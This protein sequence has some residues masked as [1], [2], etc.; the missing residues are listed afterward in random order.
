ML[1]VS[2]PRP[3][4]PPVDPRPIY[5]ARLAERSATAARWARHDDVVVL[6]RVV[7][8]VVTGGLA[9][10]AWRTEAV[11]AMWLL[12]P[13]A[14]F[15]ALVV[16][17]DRVRR[18]L[19][20]A[21]R[22]AAFYE[23][24]LARLDDRWA[25]SGEDGL[26][27]LD[28]GHPYAVDLDLFGHGSL[29]QLLCTARTGL[30]EAT[31][32][33][34][35]LAPADP[36]PLR[37]RQAAVDELRPRLDLREEVALLGDDARSGADPAA[38]AAW[39]TRRDL[40]VSR[41]LRGLAAGFGLL[42]LAALGWWW[43]LGHG[44]A[45]LLVTATAAWLFSRTL[46]GR[47]SAVIAGAENLRRDLDVL[48]PL[49][50]RI[51]REPMDSPRLVSLQ[52]GLRREGRPPS[53]ALASLRRLVDLLAARGA[54]LFAP[55]AALLLFGTQL[56]LAIEAW[57]GR[58]GAELGDWLAA[59]GEVEAVLAL[60]GYAYEHPADPFPE[61]AA[62]S[63]CFEATVLAHP[64]LPNATRV[65][66]DIRLGAAE[67]V[68]LVSGSNMSGKSTL[69]RT[70]GVN[71]VLAGAGAPVRAERLRVSPLA[72]GAAIRMEDSLRDGVSHFYAEITR[73]QQILAL[74]DGPRPLLFLADE[75]LSGTNSRDRRIGTEAIV[76]RL[77]ERGAIGLATT[78]DLSLAELADALGPRVAN[79]HFADR[80]VDG[81]M[82]F[83]Y[84]LQPG[85]AL[86]SNAL[87]L[88][89]AIGLLE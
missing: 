72:L 46:H 74:A 3:G 32:A 31:L 59:V 28:R 30:G 84:R 29:F 51:E 18:W 89:R 23:R 70:V 71:A 36:D 33:D 52:A 24:G 43:P 64:L 26:R 76:R 82:V 42:N 78:H 80:L 58:Y 47:A 2:R 41:R 49:L 12:A 68:L 13:I 7:V 50:S 62:G 4:D 79:V 11:T 81:R 14:L 9:L 34:W 88:M 63:A 39:G 60:A 69:L 21:R 56:A 77:V 44:P 85:V 37:A 55:F 27:F 8:G 54:L 25:G 66:N 65:P 16:V 10:A 53:A 67:R 75:I 5:A 57:R 40:P 19:A 20:Q 22:A 86:R 1:A 45:V 87:D 48:V 61:I 17:H 6:A 38:L 83:D 73:L 15:G 35:L